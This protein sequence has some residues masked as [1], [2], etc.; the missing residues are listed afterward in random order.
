VR[1]TATLTFYDPDHSMHLDN[2]SPWDGAVFADR[3]IRVRHTVNVPGVGRVT[4]TPFVGPIVNL[5]RDGETLAIE[6]QDKTSLAITGTRTVT[7]KKGMNA[8]DAIRKIMSNATGEDKFRLPGGIKRRL[9]KSYSTGWKAEASPWVVCSKIAALLNMQ[10]YYSCD[11]Y[12]SL[13]RPPNHPVVTLTGAAIT[14][15]VQ[16]TQDITSVANIVRVYGTLAAKKHKETKDS[17]KKK[18]DHKTKPT[19]VGAVA[20]AV[21]SHPMAPG[22]LGRNGVPRYLPKVIDGEEYKREADARQRAVNELKRSLPMTAGATFSC[23]PL[24]H[25][26]VGDLIRA[27]TDNGGLMVRLEEGSIPLGV[28]GDMSVGSQRRVSRGRRA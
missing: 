22:K 13:R 17:N 3:M 14:T 27:Q 26:D 18:G 16:V 1:R 21:K 8:V 15:P 2:D 10:L 9:P 4:A 7:A 5:S 23:V 28:T 19:K 11:G 25:L 20:E 12:L 6:C 24:F